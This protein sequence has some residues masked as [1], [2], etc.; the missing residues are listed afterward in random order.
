MNGDFELARSGWSE[1]PQGTALVRRFDDPDVTSHQITPHSGQYVLR[2][3]A[4]STNYVVHYVEQYANI[5]SGAQEITVSGQLQ[6]RTEEPPDDVYDEAYVQLAEESSPASPFFRSAPVWTN[7]TQASGWKPFT[8]TVNVASVAGKP[9]VFRVL[10][11]LDTSV[12]TYFY[13]DTLSVLVTR[14][15]P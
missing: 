14:C 12:A 13:F 15:A 8:F 11:S 9:M 5:P 2:L 10:A 4:P 3:G 7:L 1:A 6:V